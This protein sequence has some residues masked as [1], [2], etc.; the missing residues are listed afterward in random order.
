MQALQY[1]GQISAKK[2]KKKRHCL[3]LLKENKADFHNM[4]CEHRVIKKENRKRKWTV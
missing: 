4:Y 3:K 1:T 2:K